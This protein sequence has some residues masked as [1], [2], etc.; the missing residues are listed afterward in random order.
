MKNLQLYDKFGIRIDY[1]FQW[2]KNLKL[3]IK[4]ADITF[5]LPVF[6]MS[7]SICGN[8]HDIIPKAEKGDMI[9]GVPND[10]LVSPGIVYIYMCS[11]DGTAHLQ[12]IGSA[13]IPVFP[14]IKAETPTHP[15]AVV[16]TAIVGKDVVS[17]SAD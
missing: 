3:Q 16:G 15:K 8:S 17:E 2:D 7:K 12:T 1:L 11:E 9:V 13:R 6:H 4:N 10:S 14:K 5:P